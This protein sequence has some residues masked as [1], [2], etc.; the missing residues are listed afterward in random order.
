MSYSKFSTIFIKDSTSEGKPSF[1]M[2]FFISSDNSSSFLVSAVEAAA[3]VE[4]A[5]AAY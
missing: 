3:A 1:M 2:S 4:A 5:G